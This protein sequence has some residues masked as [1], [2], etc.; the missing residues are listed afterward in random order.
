MK[1]D[2]GLS[3]VEIMVATALLA[4]SVVP[5]LSLMSFGTRSVSHSDS[6]LL[7]GSLARMVIEDLKSRSYDDIQ[8][9]ASSP[10]LGDS[11]AD[12]PFRLTINQTAEAAG[13]KGLDS[14]DFKEL[15][16]RLGQLSY[17][18]DV[19]NDNPL[20]DMKSVSV[21]I[22]EKLDKGTVTRTFSTIIARWTKL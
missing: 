16:H 8:P 2:K 9:V 21:T 1:H 22:V 14:P 15:S 11:R 19:N 13:V 5:L 18:I 3:F 7:V 10:V 6:Q 12:S 20:K 17:T 4:L